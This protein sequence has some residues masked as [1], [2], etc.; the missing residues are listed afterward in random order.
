MTWHKLEYGM[1]KDLID[2]NCERN[3]ETNDLLESFAGHREKV[4]QLVSATV[5]QL[6]Q[7]GGT[8]SSAVL[9]GSGNCLDVDLPA[10]ADMFSKIHLVDL[11]E[12]ASKAAVEAS[13]VSP[14]QISIH[15]PEDIAEP[16]LSLTSRDFR[17]EEENKEH[18]IKVLQ[19]LSSENGLADIP[20][21]DVVVSQCVFTQLIDA[22]SRIIDKDHPAFANTLKALRIGHLRRLVSMLRPGGVAIFVTDLV[23]SD[24]APGL[25]TTTDESLGDTIKEL[26]NQR[27][28]FSGTNPSMVLN[29]LNV[30]SR[31]P[32]GPETVHTI[33][34]WLWDVGQRRY[35]VYALRI[36][37]RIPL[38]V[39][40]M[41][42][43]ADTQ[44]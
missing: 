10:L 12:S 2:L 17:P 4:M 41:P 39:E 24:T 33:D 43:E 35:A 38:P 25:R 7:N 8:C 27:N 16:L 26:V 36:Q 1:R 28:F 6:S 21:A 3:A 40:E 22:L 29:D 31:L 42:A 19:A 5:A 23:S 20:E 37:K 32:S 15:A 11:D 14:D 18:C 13:G 9:L 30:L 34:P 44:M